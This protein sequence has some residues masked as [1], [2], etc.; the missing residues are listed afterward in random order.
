MEWDLICLAFPLQNWKNVKYMYHACWRLWSPDTHIWKNSFQTFFLILFFDS[1]HY[2]C[3]AY[4]TYTIYLRRWVTSTRIEFWKG[5]IIEEL[6]QYRLWSFKSG[7]TKLFSILPK[8]TVLPSSEGILGKGRMADF[9]AFIA[10][11]P[12]D[13]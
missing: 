8:R 6:W 13:L 1:Y 12:F 10:S 5:C 3:I 2:K 9:P 4:K 7:D 11:K